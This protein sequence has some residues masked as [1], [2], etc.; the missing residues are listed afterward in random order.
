MGTAPKKKR[1]MRSRRSG[2][3]KTELIKNNLRIIQN[4]K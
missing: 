1:A 3:K 4:L 2:L